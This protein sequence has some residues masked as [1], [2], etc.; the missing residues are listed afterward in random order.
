MCIQREFDPNYYRI[1]PG[2]FSSDS[3]RHI[4]VENIHSYLQYKTCSNLFTHLTDTV[5][6]CVTVNN[7]E[8]SHC[9][10]KLLMLDLHA[11]P[12][13]T[14]V[15]LID[16][17]KQ[18]T[19]LNRRD[20]RRM[21]IRSKIECSLTVSRFE[22]KVTHKCD[23]SLTNPVRNDL[24]PMVSQVITYQSEDKRYFA[25]GPERNS[26]VSTK[27]LTDS[28]TGITLFEYQKYTDGKQHEN[29]TYLSWNEADTFNKNAF[30]ATCTNVGA[31]E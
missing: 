14:N 11:R 4:K 30:G 22:R 16:A 2:L 27:D 18:N 26:I 20:L 31:T 6:I 17:N 7:T 15:E 25:L 12:R 21:K 1:S 28:W 3:F 8:L 5:Q 29:A 9:G 24:G 13:V 19:K 23:F 10:C